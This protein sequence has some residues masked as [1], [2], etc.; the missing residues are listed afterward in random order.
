MKFE[1]LIIIY[2]F[3]A[4]ATV[5]HCSKLILEQT[6]SHL[7]GSN[8]EVLSFKDI[9]L[10]SVANLRYVVTNVLP[11]KE[12]ACCFKNTDLLNNATNFYQW[13]QLT[14]LKQN[15]QSTVNSLRM[16]QV[17]HSS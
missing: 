5:P 7:F 15:A 17:F 13:Y 4:L 2:E 3:G 1:H 8:I 12:L 14:C 10:S 9:V 11:I 16:F 6:I